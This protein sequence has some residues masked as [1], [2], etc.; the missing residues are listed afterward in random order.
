[1]APVKRRPQTR[2]NHKKGR[3]RKPNISELVYKY[4]NLDDGKQGGEKASENYGGK[5][6]FCKLQKRREEVLDSL[7]SRNTKN[8]ANKRKDSSRN[9]KLRRVKR[10]PT[11]RDQTLSSCMHKSNGGEGIKKMK[12]YIQKA[13]DFGVESGYLIPKDAAYKVLRV[14]SDLMND[15]NHKARK[16]GSPVSQARGKGARQTPIRFEDYEVQ[17]ARR[18]RR[19]RGRKR[20]RRSRSGS[21]RRRRSRRRSRRGRRR[22]GSGNADEVI[23]V[24]NEEYEYKNQPEK[25]NTTENANRGD[26]NDRVN[27]S[28]R[29]KVASKRD[30]EEGSDLSVDEDETDDEEEKK[31]DDTTKS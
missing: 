15:V 2:S 21:R 14:S 12:R 24:E 22:S 9:S 7:D 4:L 8:M 5:C 27:Q 11:T 10:R 29:E 25:R 20:R 16:S 30:D 17:D 3:R 6:S 26:D 19:R 31:R 1:M 28:D 18:G 13:L 23:E